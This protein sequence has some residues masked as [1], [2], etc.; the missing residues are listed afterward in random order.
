MINI[1]SLLSLFLLWIVVSV[2]NNAEF[3]YFISRSTVD[4]SD[5]VRRLYDWKLRRQQ[6]VAAVELIATDK[7]T[8][9]ITQIVQMIENF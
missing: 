5:E 3:S 8:V 6:I 2:Y 1:E 7:I 4:S 9:T